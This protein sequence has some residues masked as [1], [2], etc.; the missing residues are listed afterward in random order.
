MGEA[1][2]FARYEDFERRELRFPSAPLMPD[3][4]REASPQ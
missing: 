2:I 1:V 4:G 3:V